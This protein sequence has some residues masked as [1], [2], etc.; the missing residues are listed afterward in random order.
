MLAPLTTVVLVEDLK[1]SNSKGSLP[2]HGGQ[3]LENCLLL[4]WQLS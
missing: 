2:G 4:N 3:I 1:V